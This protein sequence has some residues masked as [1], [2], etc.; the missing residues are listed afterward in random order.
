[1][2]VG[3][4]IKMCQKHIIESNIKTILRIKVQT[5]ILTIQK[6]LKSNSKSVIHF[7]K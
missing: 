4:T 5:R 2:K 7:N 6:K 3:K 1:M